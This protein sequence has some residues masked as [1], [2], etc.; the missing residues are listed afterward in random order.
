L[1]TD[2]KKYCNLEIQVRGHSGSLKLVRGSAMDPPGDLST[3]CFA[4]GW[5]CSKY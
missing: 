5:H 2:F 1:T 3:G 4:Y